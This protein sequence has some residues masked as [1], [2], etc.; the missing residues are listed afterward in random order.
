MNNEFVTYKQASALKELG[1]GGKCIATIQNNGYIHI[2]GTRGF[3]SAAV[4][5]DK[6]DVPLKSQVFRWFREKYG[7]YHIIHC[8]SE[9]I[10]LFTITNMINEPSVHTD[11]HIETYEEAEN[12]CI[13]KLIEIAKQK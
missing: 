7:L 1:Y 12:A 6:V 3:P 10:A 11:R 4:V 9:K 5:I 8:A 2:K 13:D